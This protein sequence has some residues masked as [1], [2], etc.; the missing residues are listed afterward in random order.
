MKSLFQQ[1]G[2][3]CRKESDYVIPNLKDPETNSIEIDI[4]E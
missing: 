3:T 4:H 1:F 2:G